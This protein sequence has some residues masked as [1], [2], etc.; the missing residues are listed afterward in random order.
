MMDHFE[1]NAVAPLLLTRTLQDLLK[2]GSSTSQ[3]SL[4][5]NIAAGWGS[6]ATNE[7]SNHIAYRTSK[8]ALHMIGKSLSIDLKSDSIRV[9]SLHPGW[10][11]TDMG[12]SGGREPP[13]DVETSVRHMLET[14]SKLEDKS[15]GMLL[16][17][18]GTVIPF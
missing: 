4:V 7:D 10:V 16:N 5:V 8:S 6:I 2:Q 14:I 3:P 15:N 17:F 18:D 11:A 13:L 1:T 9:V 12:S